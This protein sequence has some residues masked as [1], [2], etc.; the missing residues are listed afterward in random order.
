MS[1]RVTKA[2]AQRAVLHEDDEAIRVPQRR[3]LEVGSSDDPAEVEAD[4]VAADVIRRLRTMEVSDVG[5]PVSSTAGD[6]VRRSTTPPGSPASGV[7]PPRIRRRSDPSGEP[8]VGHGGGALS[9]ELAGR[10]ESARRA[11]GTPLDR[12]TKASMES[13]F[14]ADFSSV[15]VHTGSEPDQLNRSL[16]AKAFTVGSD[17]FFSGNAYSPGSETG[18]E[19][20]AHELT[21]TVQQ[22]G[23]GVQRRSTGVTTT[24]V[25]VV[26]RLTVAGTRWQKTKKV[27]VLQSGASGTVASFDD[28]RGSVIVKS[29]QMIGAE[30]AVAAGLFDAVDGGKQDGYSG[31]APAV[32][33]ASKDEI[34]AIRGVTQG[35]LKGDPRNFVAGLG[36][37]MTL[38]MDRFEGENVKDLLAK[39]QTKKKTFSKSRKMDSK[40]LASQIANEPGPLT[41][42]GR[43]AGIDIVMG[44][45]D[46]CVNAYNADNFMFDPKKKRFGFVDNTE[47]WSGGFLTSV[48]SNDLKK[49]D[50]RSGFHD[51]CTGFAYVD[52]FARNDMDALT[53]RIYDNLIDGGVVWD[54]QK[55]KEKHPDVQAVEDLCTQQAPAMRQWLKNGLVQGRAAV[56]AALQNPVALTSGLPPDKQHD[57]V[58]SLVARRSFLEGAIEAAAWHAGQQR[59]TQLLG[60]RPDK[61]FTGDWM[62]VL[63][64]FEAFRGTT[65]NTV[66][67][68]LHAHERYRDR[69]SYSMVEA[70]LH[71]DAL[72]LFGEMKPSYQRRIDAIA[73]ASGLTV[74]EVQE[75]FPSYG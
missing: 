69:V 16:N 53:D 46:R 50:P 30:V 7:R 9:G 38:V 12:S 6:R 23:A 10:I 42:L 29:N 19:L 59:A 5:D 26:Q 4:R 15:S 36:Q 71:T 63:T 54:M 57:A 43:S 13:A 31:S 67:G 52:E 55:T 51:W 60:A 24:P 33:V 2:D 1:E 41:V 18:R 22:G 45:G 8:R 48:I 49:S 14:G 32:R 11:G 37:N 39:R 34:A 64:F 61:E 21:H 47:N 74:A 75:M 66:E 25:E 35:K 58:V 72:D 20:L 68:L 73:T 62:D 27:S 44:M 56:L 65:P 28:G 17:I 3:G 70:F 40:S